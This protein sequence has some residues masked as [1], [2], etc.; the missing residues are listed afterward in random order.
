MPK[1]VLPAITTASASPISQRQRTALIQRIHADPTME[2]IDR[3]IGLLVLLYAQPLTRIV[4]LTL[5]DVIPTGDDVLIRLG[6][7]PVPVPKPFA[8]L[9]T[10][11][12]ANRSNLTTATNPGSQLLFPAAEPANL[13]TR[14]RCDC[15]C[16]DSESPSST[17][18]P[19]Q[20]A[21]SCSKP[22][23][24]SSQQCSATTPARREDR[25]RSRRNLETLRRRQPQQPFR[26]QRSSRRPAL[27]AQTHQGPNVELNMNRRQTNTRHRRY[28]TI[29]TA[30]RRSNRDRR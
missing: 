7:P 23:H 28:S 20:S 9:L 24:P 30:D 12:I 26:P 21:S 5:A 6:D 16:N 22:Q 1:L 15:A 25:G 27:T 19:E 3:V 17:A 4:Q 13:S 10:G 8:E 14:P 2:P 11:Y 29:E 18:E